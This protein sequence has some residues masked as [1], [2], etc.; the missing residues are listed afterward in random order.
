MKVRY[1]KK[2]LLIPLSN[3]RCSCVVRL[4][5]DDAMVDWLMIAIICIKRS[6][7]R[8]HE[9]VSAV[10]S[11]GKGSMCGF[12]VTSAETVRLCSCSFDYFWEM[13]RFCCWILR[14]MLRWISDLIMHWW[15]ECYILMCL[16]GDRSKILRCF[17]GAWCQIFIFG[18]MLWK[19]VSSFDFLGYLIT[20]LVCLLTALPKSYVNMWCWSA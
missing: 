12:C 5:I 2:I 9:F 7:L 13:Y 15:R 20:G 8:G 19:T 1:T 10:K 18:Y 17:V 16:C 6:G 11:I 3:G 4:S 14:L